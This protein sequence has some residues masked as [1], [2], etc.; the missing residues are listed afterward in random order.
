MLKDNI[1]IAFSGNFPDRLAEAARF[2]R[3]LAEFRRVARWHLSPALEI[4]AVDDALGPEVENVFS[5]RLVRDNPDGVGAGR[6]NKLDA[7]HAEA[8]GGAPYQNVVAGLE[9]VRRMPEQHPIRGRK[10]KRVASRLFPGE[11]ARLRHQLA[12]LH[13]AE[14]RERSVRSLVAPDALRRREQGIATVAILVVAIIL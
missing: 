10:R 8:A 7:E 4:F 5:L 3:P 13:A 2:L 9:G 1:D 11:M 12:R 14:L 6:S